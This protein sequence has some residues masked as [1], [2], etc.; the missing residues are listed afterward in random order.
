MRFLET[1]RGN[2]DKFEVALLDDRLNALKKYR[3][4]AVASP[5][6]VYQ[7]GQAFLKIKKEQLIDMV[8]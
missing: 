6:Q 8:E 4:A 5:K 3:T 2:L 7:L 1:H